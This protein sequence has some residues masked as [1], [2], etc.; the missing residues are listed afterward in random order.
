MSSILI[1][2]NKE[3]KIADDLNRIVP[4]NNSLKIVTV[5]IE[6]LMSGYSITHELFENGA[7]TTFT[8]RSNGKE[9]NLES[10]DL[11][12]SRISHFYQPNFPDAKDVAY[13]SMEWMAL[14]C[15]I[16]QS[17]RKKMVNFNIHLLLNNNKIN[18]FLFMELCKKNKIKIDPAM[19]LHQTHD[20]IHTTADTGLSK[21]LFLKNHFMND[22]P[23]V[24]KHL[25]CSLME[26]LH[27][28]FAEI[29]FKD[30]KAVTCNPF[31]ICGTKNEI[32][33]IYESLLSLI[34]KSNGVNSRN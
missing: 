5:P 3:D 20:A 19:A 18:P 33:F 27:Y 6:E 16:F 15:S 8:K 31:P 9:I 13:A 1:F 4:G 10:F 32:R 24:H 23:A 22:I 34:K 12:F 30:E 14:I 25:I 17:C 29:Y 28:E 2:C 21:I 7:H 11:I 26:D